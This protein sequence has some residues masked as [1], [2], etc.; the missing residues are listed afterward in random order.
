M[1]RLRDDLE[2]ADPRQSVAQFLLAHPWHRGAVA[3]V[4]VVGGLRYG[5]VRT[6]T[7]AADFLP[8][9]VQRLQL[10][11]YGMENFVP[12]STD[13]LR[14]TLFVGAPRVS[15]VAAGAADDDWLFV[16]PPK[17]EEEK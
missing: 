5:E 9:N 17:H 14:V 1:A 8:L 6:N 4:Q 11:V 16:G 2:K 13:W 12:Q 15:D 3:R 10:A 7:L